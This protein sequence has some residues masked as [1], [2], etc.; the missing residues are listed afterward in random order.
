MTYKQKGNQDSSCEVYSL[1]NKDILTGG[2][3]KE[4]KKKEEKKEAEE[5]KQNNKE[6]KLEERKQCIFQNSKKSNQL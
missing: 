6:N 2:G 4:G 5:Q 3:K 1:S